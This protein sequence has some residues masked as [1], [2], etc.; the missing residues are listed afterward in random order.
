MATYYGAL[1]ADRITGSSSPDNIYGYG[2]DS[3]PEDETGNDYLRGG[4]G[5]DNIYGGGGNDTLLGD[6]GGDK[7]Y[8]GLGNDTLYGGRG[9]DHFD[10]GAGNDLFVVEDDLMD[11]FRGGLGTD[12]IR[13]D[14]FVAYQR[15]ILPKEAS[16]EILDL[17]GFTLSGTNYA[18]NFDF[19]GVSSIR[20][21]GEVINLGAGNDDYIGHA[22]ADFVNAGGDNDKLFGGAGD[23][24]FSGGS[25]ADTFDG[26][27]GDDTFLIADKNSDVFLGGSGFDT[28]RLEGA[29]TRYRLILDSAAGVE[30]LDRDGYTLNGTSSADIF[31][32]SGLTRFVNSGSTIDLGG[33][34]DLYIGYGGTDKVIGGSGND[35]LRA[36]AGNDTLDGGTGAD[37]LEGGTGNDSYVIDNK[38][39]MVTEK[40]S[41]GSD[42]VR[43]SI[44]Y[45]L[46]SNVE[47]LSLTGT[48]DI[49]GKGNGLAN[50]I[51]GNSGKNTLASAGGNDILK[52]G[53]GD[54]RLIGGLGSDDL[55][56]GSGKDSFVFGSLQAST[57]SEAGRDTVFD[58]AK[59]DRI[60]LKAIDAKVG[61]TTNDAFTFIGTKGFSKTAGELRFEK[62]A[63]DIYVYGDVNG[64]GKADFS[65]H[66]DN[67]ASL[68]KDD[69]LL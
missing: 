55:Y 8:G 2:K 23:D 36:G 46:T 27:T 53:S 7:L 39:D 16:V 62:N 58:F 56:G 24:V 43:S 50:A 63:S 11:T 5:N 1:G 12:R 48:G 65:I 69:F 6:D 60:D 51:T 33:S 4:G 31:N 68:G 22:G 15:L 10:G 20:Y 44:T 37:T 21:G 40:A 25:G 30:Q 17:N 29:A 57:V 13:L 61:T 67:L 52:G 41:A 38:D 54:D 3:F 64:D 35:T 47:N 66:I 9:N 18:D 28:V 32:L 26:G 14:D 59:G 34:N 45:T 42:I 19:S 49:S